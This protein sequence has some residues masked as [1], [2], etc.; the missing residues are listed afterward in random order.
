MDYSDKALSDYNLDEEI[1]KLS[2]LIGP[3]HS[4]EFDIYRELP[5]GFNPQ[6]SID[7]NR[8]KRGFTEYIK[9]E[10]S[11]PDISACINNGVC[12]VLISG[13][14]AVKFKNVYLSLHFNEAI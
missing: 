3:M 13:E 6:E 14:V 1:E 7:E 11:K 4:D 8:N 5:E 2:D 9:I 10:G 12:Q